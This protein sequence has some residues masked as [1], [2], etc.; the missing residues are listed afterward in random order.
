MGLLSGLSVVEGSAFVAAP[1]A[2]MSLAQLGADV[3]RFDAL[4]G[5]FDARRW[6]LTAE[7]RSIYWAGLNK[8]KR[9]FAVDVRSP[10]GREL[11]AQLICRSGPGKGIF[12][13]NLSPGGALA[14]EAL[15][16]RRRDVIVLNLLGNPDGS[17]AVDYTVNSA[18]GIPFATGPERAGGTAPVNNALP[19]WD[20]TTGMTAAFG[21]LAAELHRRATGEGQHVK[22]ALSDVGFAMVGALGYIGEAAVNK[23]DRPATGNFLYGAFG[24]EFETKDGR[25]I[26]VVAITERMWSEIVKV[27]GTAEAMASLASASGLDLDRDEG[28]R[29]GVRAEIK[30]AMAPWFR[31]RTLGEV[32]AALKATGVCWGPYRTPTEMLAEDPRAS[33]ANPMFTVLDQHGIGRY[34]VPGSPLQV[35]AA[36]REAPRTA[37]RLGEHTDEILAGELGLTQTQIG[38]LRDKKIVGGPIDVVAP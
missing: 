33:A 28:A 6:P 7:K 29:Y 13:T 35:S 23:E 20:L 32:E 21:L 31:A 15:K 24:C 34:P 27:T 16:E 18:V 9:S 17:T 3:I 2:G 22:L 1:L 14:Y 10:E 4:T 38:T 30:A 8:G 25:F 36:P 19:A 26:Y 37:P 12:L 5:G 11:V